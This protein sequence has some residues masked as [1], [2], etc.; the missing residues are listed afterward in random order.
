M[1]RKNTSRAIFFAAMLVLTLLLFGTGLETRAHEPVDGA[2]YCFAI[3]PYDGGVYASTAPEADVYKCTVQHS[4]GRGVSHQRTASRS[5]EWAIDQGYGWPYDPGRTAPYPRYQSLWDTRRAEWLALIDPP[6]VTPTPTADEDDDPPMVDPPADEM[7]SFHLDMNRDC[8]LDDHDEQWVRDNV[9]PGDVDMLIT[10]IQEARDEGYCTTETE[11]VPQGASSTGDNNAGG[12]TDG[13]SESGDRPGGGTQ[14]PEQEDA[15]GAH[16]HE[17]D[18][19]ASHGHYTGHLA[20]TNHEHDDLA[21]ADALAT[22]V[23]RLNLFESLLSETVDAET[24]ERETADTALGGR[25]DAETQARTAADTALAGRIDTN[26]ER[27]DDHDVRIQLNRESIDVNRDDIRV[28]AAG[29]AT[30]STGI[31][32]NASA[33]ETHSIMLGD[34][35]ERLVQHD[36]RITG[37]TTLISNNFGLI[38]E[39]RG[40]I[41]ENH[42]ALA[43]QHTRISNN[44]NRIDDLSG[45]LSSVRDGVASAMAMGQIPIS[46]GIGVGVGV[47][48]YGGHQAVALGGGYT[49]VLLGREMMLRGAA[50]QTDTDDAVAVGFGVRF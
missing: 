46:S 23:A 17:H 24:V 45:K 20:R 15:G 35:E 32:T 3:D 26:V 13:G 19:V 43:A 12:D 9:S 40:L 50:T 11:C 6:V 5:R 22:T 31:A 8:V 37:N 1:D 48:D 14:T 47:S 30:N 10:A 4:I 25:I 28:N 38:A 44:T 7:C 34:H 49:F 21:T 39:N 27:L 29:I 18:E 36:S 33:I 16:E 42:D 41:K 2:T